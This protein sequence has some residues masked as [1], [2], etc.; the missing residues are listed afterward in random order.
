M[1]TKSESAA[2]VKTFQ[3]AEEELA[4]L[5]KD[6]KETMGDD[7]WEVF[8]NALDARRSA[9]D[10][11]RKSVREYGRPVGPFDVQQK[12]VNTWDTE[13]ALSLA[14]R[15]KEVDSLLSLGVLSYAFDSKKAE[16]ALD[17]KVFGI[18]KDACHTKQPGTPAILG[19]KPEDDVLR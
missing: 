5:I 18:Y 16:K 1:S 4:G 19:P 13:K 2:A 3:D 8:L 17:E 7:F 12:Q 15:R 9:C 11:A 10:M 14:K 6:I